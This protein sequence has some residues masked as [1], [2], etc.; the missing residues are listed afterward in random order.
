MQRF[1]T[2][3]FCLL[4]TLALAA[5]DRDDIDI[6]QLD[7]VRE[8]R[9]YFEQDNW[10][11][12]LDS[13][14]QIGDGDQRLIGDVVC[15][16]TLRGGGHTLQ[17]QQLL[18]QRPQKRLQQAPFNIDVNETDKDHKMPGGYDKLKLSNVFRD[19]FFLREVL[20]YDAANRFMV[21]SRANYVRVFINDDY[22][23]LYNNTESVD[24]E[25]FEHFFDEDDGILFKCDPSWGYKR[26]L[27]AKRAINPRCSIWAKIP[28]ATWATIRD[29]NRPRLERA[30]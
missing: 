4:I 2:L 18:L 1:F 27:L 3:S 5:Q 6:Y 15:R 14:K 24:D 13:L 11:D 23:G 29:Q 28:L 25:L 9:I 12:I 21:S 8:V 22:F 17:G 16:R 7:S 26:L 30:H 19:P 20:A 10:D